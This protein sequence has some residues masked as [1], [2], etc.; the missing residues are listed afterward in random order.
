[1]DWL[2]FKTAAIIVGKNTA[3]VLATNALGL[4]ISVMTIAQL[5]IHG[6][7]GAFYSAIGKAELGLQFLDGY[8]FMGKGAWHMYKANKV[9]MSEIKALNSGIIAASPEVDIVNGMVEDVK[10]MVEEHIA[11]SETTL[12]FDNNIYTVGQLDEIHTNLTVQGVSQ[13]SQEDLIDMNIAHYHMEELSDLPILNTEGYSE[14]QLESIQINLDAQG[15]SKESQEALVEMNVAHLHMDDL[16]NVPISNHS[17]GYSDEQLEEIRD[18][19][20]QQG[21]SQET[22]DTLIE[23][24]IAQFH[25]EEPRDY[26][27]DR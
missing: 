26:R 25:M 11:V 1:M 3:N 24:N 7:L 27:I 15:I 6:S 21:V 20:T 9:L 19:L 17:G 5:G 8:K 2:L 22:Q 4:P 23:M 14:E 18:N 13:G 16:S 10:D 12:E